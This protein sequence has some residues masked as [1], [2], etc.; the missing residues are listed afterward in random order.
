MHT[1]QLSQAGDLS[2]P[3]ALPSTRARW[4]KQENDQRHTTRSFPFRRLP[5]ARSPAETPFNDVTPGWP[6]TTAWVD[7][8]DLLARLG[9]GCPRSH[10]VLIRLLGRHSRAV[11]AYSSTQSARMLSHSRRALGEGPQVRMPRASARQLDAIAVVA[12]GKI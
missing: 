6:N 8:P 9:G 12:N 2:G 4:L 1:K 3:S 7:V 10:S 11:P 5:C